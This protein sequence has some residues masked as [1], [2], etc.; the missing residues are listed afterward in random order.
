MQQTNLVEPTEL[1]R[2]RNHFGIRRV[3][4]H[5]KP[6]DAGASAPS[7]VPLNWLRLFVQLFAQCNFIHTYV[8]ILNLRKMPTEIFREIPFVFTY[9]NHWNLI[10]RNFCDLS[11]ALSTAIKNQSNLIIEILW[12]LMCWKNSCDKYCNL[13]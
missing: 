13:Y 2:D 5:S 7:S 10:R 1:L 11:K 8:R 4:W 6:R 9:L 3:Q 12:V